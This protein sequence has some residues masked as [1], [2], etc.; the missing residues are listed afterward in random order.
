MHR[1]VCMLHKLL[2]ILPVDIIIPAITSI[3]DNIISTYTVNMNICKTRLTHTSA[4]ETILP[5]GAGGCPCTDGVWDN[6]ESTESDLA[7]PEHV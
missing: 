7:A 6:T 3:L 2:H 4:F 1:S 5:A